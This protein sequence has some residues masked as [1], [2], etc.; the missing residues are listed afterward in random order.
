MVKPGLSQKA[1]IRQRLREVESEIQ[2]EMLERGFEPSQLETTALPKS[3]AS[4]AAERQE[5]LLELQDDSGELQMSE[6]NRI[7]NQLRRAFEGGAWHGPSVL[8]ILEGVDAKTAAS[9]PIPNAHSIWEIARHIGAWERAFKSRLEGDRAN[10]EG[11]EDWPPVTDVSEEAWNATRQQLVEG[12]Q[13]L[14]RRVLAIEESALDKPILPGLSSVYDTIHGV[15]QHD[16][17]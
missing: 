9:H 6:V 1:G 4:L 14:R 11:E 8:E 10:L 2:R 5:L 16:L 13:N 7:E 3:L 15:V 17:Y 12:N